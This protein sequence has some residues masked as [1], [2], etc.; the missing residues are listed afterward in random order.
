MFNGTVNFLFTFLLLL[1]LD[2]ALL[3]AGTEGDADEARSGRFSLVA[4]AL[5]AATGVAVAVPRA[6]PTCPCALPLETHSRRRCRLGAPAGAGPGRVLPPDPG[7]PDRLARGYAE[8]RGPVWV[9][10]RSTTRTRPRP[11]GAAAARV[12]SSPAGAGADLSERRRVSPFPGRR[13]RARPRRQPRAGRGAAGAG[14]DPVLVPDPGRAHR[15]ATIGTAARLLYNRLVRGRADG[16]LVRIAVAMPE[17]RGWRRRP[18]PVKPTSS[19]SS[20]RLCSGACR[21]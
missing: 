14:R 13:G 1:A 8:A 4:L 3:G 10:R 15:R 7:A 6:A 18:S 21:R 20:T 2:S 11:A 5:L 19:G 17:R 16:A 9:C 12:S